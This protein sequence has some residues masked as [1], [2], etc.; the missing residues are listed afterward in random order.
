MK[1]NHTPVQAARNGGD[2]IKTFPYRETIPTRMAAPDVGKLTGLAFTAAID[3][4]ARLRR[5]RD[6]GAYLGLVPR[7][8]QSGD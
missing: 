5:S 6:V 4:A 3:D 7:R 8:Y 1:E 2:V